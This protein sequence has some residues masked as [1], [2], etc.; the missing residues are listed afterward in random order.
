[1]TIKEAAQLVVQA[2][3]LANGGDL[4]LLDMGNPVYIFDLAKQ[5]ISLSGLTLKDKSN[6]DGDIEITITGLRA[7]EKLYEELLIDAK[8]EATSHPL[9]FRANEK[10]IPS[11]QLFESLKE[12]ELDLNNFSEKEVLNKLKEL[13]PEWERN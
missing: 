12:L 8:S 3:S 4:F 9:I 5:M 6:P 11:N 10:S 13:V 1:M 7:G 2:S